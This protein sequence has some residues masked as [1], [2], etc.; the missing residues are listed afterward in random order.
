M[1]ISYQ[2]ESWASYYSDPDLLALWQEHYDE[3]EPA[4]RGL[5]PM[6]PDVAGYE[7]LESVGCL[8]VQTV[9]RDGRLIG[10]CTVVVRR[11]IH[12]PT[13]CGF[14]DSYFVSR[15]ERKGLIGYKLLRKTL[16]ELKRL[17]CKRVYFMTKEFNTI[18]ILLERLGMAK[19]D[20]VYAMWLEG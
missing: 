10:Y 19:I 20:S 12:Y 16:D 1:T 7:A 15:L 14:E 5:M 11:H 3:L 17:G 9:R 6:G 2:T 18:A 4:H 13:V 8:L